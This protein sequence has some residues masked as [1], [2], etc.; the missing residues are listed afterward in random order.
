MSPSFSIRQGLTRRVA[1]GKDQTPPSTPHGDSFNA[2]ADADPVSPVM[3]VDKPDTALGRWM[4]SAIDRSGIL[5]YY[6]SA[7]PLTRAHV[8][9]AREAMTQAG[10]GHVAFLVGGRPPHKQGKPD[11]LPGKE[12]LT[13]AKLALSDEKRMAVASLDVLLSL[14][15]RSSAMYAENQHGQDSALIA[16]LKALPRNV[17]FPLLI[18]RDALEGDQLSHRGVSSGALLDHAL[19]IQGVCE[20]EAPIEQV[21]LKGAAAPVPIATRAFQRSAEGIHSTAVR[22][23]MAAGELPPRDSI[24][25]SQ[26]EYIRARQLYG[27]PHP[28]PFP[29]WDDAQ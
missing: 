20:G 23:A 28:R 7:N 1:F 21:S 6:V 14:L 4:Q 15:R 25:V 13:L 29:P 3:P 22:R 12:R 26:G 27:A 9:Y 11:F 5:L 16:T 8:T 17:R 24:T 18:G 19:I 10:F 2:N